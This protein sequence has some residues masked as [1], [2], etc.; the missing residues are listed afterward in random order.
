MFRVG[1]SVSFYLLIRFELGA[2]SRLAITVHHIEGEDAD[3]HEGGDDHE[4]DRGCVS[5]MRRRAFESGTLRLVRDINPNPNP[6]P[7]TL[8]L[9]G[10]SCGAGT[11]DGRVTRHAGMQ[12]SKVGVA[13]GVA[14]RV[15]GHCVCYSCDRME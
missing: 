8:T 6:N 2:G 15:H 11:G 3:K 5:C 14:T 4:G 1:G 10:G 9:I 12:Y 13:A 7:L